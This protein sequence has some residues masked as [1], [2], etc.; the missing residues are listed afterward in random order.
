MRKAFRSTRWILWALKA[1]IT[2]QRPSRTMTKGS[3]LFW[4]KLTMPL[5]GYKLA[6]SGITTPTKRWSRPNYLYWTSLNLK[7]TSSRKLSRRRTI[8]YSTGL[9]TTTTIPET[10]WIALRCCHSARSQTTKVPALTWT[11]Q[12]TNRESSQM[13]P[14]TSGSETSRETTT[15]QRHKT[16]AT[17]WTSWT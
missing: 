1:P 7:L 5:K 9:W 2:P 6:S 14:L 15:L 8:P 10:D 17:S 4:A 3:R 13:T 16:W 12:P 11:T